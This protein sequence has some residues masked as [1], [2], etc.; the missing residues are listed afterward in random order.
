MLSCD[1]GF[2]LRDPL[3]S[4]PD[5][6]MSH[7]PG[8]K[9]E[10]ISYEWIKA[11]GGAM[12]RIFCGQTGSYQYY[13]EFSQSVSIGGG[14]GAI[15]NASASYTASVNSGRGA[16]IN[17]GGDGY[18]YKGEIIV[19]Q[20]TSASGT[21]TTSGG[22]GATLR[23]LWNVLWYGVAG[24]MPLI[25]YKTDATDTAYADDYG[26]MICRKPCKTEQPPVSDR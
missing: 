11:E 8:N 20:I 16:S 2:A 12:P 7:L 13:V 25:T 1:A 15:V 5:T 4:T 10:R 18:E 6:T 23:N 9:W 14:G 3:P 24:L 19:L 21:Y 22:F 26:L 17:V